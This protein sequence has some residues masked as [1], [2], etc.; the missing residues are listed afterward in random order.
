MKQSK[1]PFEMAF[2]GQD[3]SPPDSPIAHEDSESQ[4]LNANAQRIVDGQEDEDDNI[5]THSISQS[6][7]K[8]PTVA[9]PS[10]AAAAKT[11]EEEEEEEEEN[12]DVELGKFAASGDPDK[13]AKMQ[14][15][16]HPLTFLPF[17]SFN[18]PYSLA[19]EDGLILFPLVFSN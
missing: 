17:Y 11:K 7:L 13:M 8:T 16:S 18:F 1:D 4:S 9:A 10:S 19:H 6:T 15:M 14:L 12:M 2:E 3:E 5:A